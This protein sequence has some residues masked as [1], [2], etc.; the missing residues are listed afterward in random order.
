MGAFL[1]LAL[2][3]A[4]AAAGCRRVDLPPVADVSGLVTLDGEP[5]AGADV[6][7]VP[8]ASA[9]TEGAPGVGFTD[10]SGRYELTTAK[11]R[12]AIIGRHKVRVE[13]R[14]EPQSE[15]DSLPPLITPER[16]S[17]PETSGLA[18][19]VT[20]GGANEI[21]LELTTQPQEPR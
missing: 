1:L 18:F 4:L 13:A 9:G 5:L 3:P 19:D 8:D 12:G 20:A 15:W 21:N 10:E 16:Y 11:V 14:G 6:Q 2:L 17:D 7:F